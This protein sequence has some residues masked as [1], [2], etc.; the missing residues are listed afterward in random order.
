MTRGPH[1]MDHGAIREATRGKRVRPSRAKGTPRGKCTRSNAPGD[2]AES[3]LRSTL[4]SCL[5]LARIL[6]ETMT[7]RSPGRSHRPRF[8]VP[9]EHEI[10]SQARDARQIKAVGIRARARFN[11]SQP[12]ATGSPRS[13]R[14]LRLSVHCVGICHPRRPGGPLETDHTTQAPGGRKL[15]DH[16]F[17]FAS[18]VGCLVVDPTLK[19]PPPFVN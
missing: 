4:A 17:S 13:S 3:G 1:R 15:K 7:K 2:T 8:P 18:G 6:L 14:S 11:Q 5:C 9:G 12:L 19:Q 16:R 10:R